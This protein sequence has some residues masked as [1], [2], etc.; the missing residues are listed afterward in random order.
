[1]LNAHTYPVQNLPIAN[2]NGFILVAIQY[3]TGAFGFLS[4]DEVHRF[5]IVNA[6][7]HD[8]KKKISVQP[9]RLS[10]QVLILEQHCNYS[11]IMFFAQ[12]LIS[13]ISFTMR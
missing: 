7:L 11:A 1:M 4:S 9:N 3:R 5:G 8:R 2:D 10:R 12:S 6:G 13:A